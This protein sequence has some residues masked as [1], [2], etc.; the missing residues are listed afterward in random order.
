MKYLEVDGRVIH[1]FAGQCGDVH[2]SV[3]LSRDIEVMG[4][5]LRELLEKCHQSQVVV[6]C[7]LEGKKKRF[8]K[9]HKRNR[10]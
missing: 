4:A 6:G 7:N 2:A 10:M 9:I 1:D 8:R 3:T 5:V